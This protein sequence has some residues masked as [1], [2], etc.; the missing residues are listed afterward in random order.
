MFAGSGG[1]RSVG[2]T[3]GREPVAHEAIC[4]VFC[5][6]RF[7]FFQL[8]S[9]RLRRFHSR[10]FDFMTIVSDASHLTQMDVFSLLGQSPWDRVMSSLALSRFYWNACIFL[11]RFRGSACPL[12]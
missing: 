9:L 4:T 3:D 11:G 6:R 1:G 2:A 5:G 8:A 10:C 12:F 7:L